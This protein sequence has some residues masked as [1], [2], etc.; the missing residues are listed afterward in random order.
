MKSFL[1]EE[2]Y[3]VHDFDYVHQTGAHWAA[4]RNNT[5]ILRVLLEN[6]ANPNV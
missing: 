2:S 6:G 3:L 1:K 4:K 5:S